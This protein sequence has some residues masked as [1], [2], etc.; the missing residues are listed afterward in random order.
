[1]NY[2]VHFLSITS[3]I[4]RSLKHRGL[5][6]KDQAQVCTSTH[7]DTNSIMIHKSRWRVYLRLLPLLIATFRFFSSSIGFFLLYLSMNNFLNIT[8]AFWWRF[9]SFCFATTIISQLHS[10]PFCFWNGK[11]SSLVNYHAHNWNRPLAYDIIDNEINNEC[12]YMTWNHKRSQKVWEYTPH[13]SHGMPTCTHACIN[14]IYYAL[15]FL[16]NT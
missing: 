14:Y 9:A 6:I 5:S 2:T 11:N 15:N 4:P 10:F 16:A 1:M 12:K 7:A 13:Y 3:W 8:Q